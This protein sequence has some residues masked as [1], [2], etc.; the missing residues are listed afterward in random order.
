MYTEK[1][2]QIYFINMM[3]AFPLKIMKVK[4]AL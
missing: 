4:R 2:Q 1:Q 3:E